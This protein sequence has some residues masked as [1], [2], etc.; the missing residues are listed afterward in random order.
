MIRFM[1]ESEVAWDSLMIVVKLETARYR[2][3]VFP[4]MDDARPNRSGADVE[5]R[6]APTSSCS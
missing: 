1:R 5:F 2:I 6:L 4:N 3:S